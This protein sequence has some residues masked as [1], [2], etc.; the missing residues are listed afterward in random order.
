MSMF[1]YQNIAIK[2]KGSLSCLLSICETSQ[3]IL[4]AVFLAEFINATSSVK[5]HLF[6]GVERV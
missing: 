3:I 2:Q 6:T 1:G 5:N 4:H